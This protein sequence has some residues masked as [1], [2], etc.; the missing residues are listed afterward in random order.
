MRKGVRID[1]H[2]PQ[3]GSCR[4]G[5]NLPRRPCRFPRSSP[6]EHPFQVGYSPLEVGDEFVLAILELEL[7]RVEVLQHRLEGCQILFPTFEAHTRLSLGFSGSATMGLLSAVGLN[8]RGGDAA[9][10]GPVGRLVANPNQ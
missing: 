3:N 6:V 4:T 8:T 2:K 5:K 7:A 9:L 1:R 10:L